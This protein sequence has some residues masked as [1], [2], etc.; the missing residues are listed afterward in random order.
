MTLLAFLV[1]RGTGLC[2]D[3]DRSLRFF[4]IPEVSRF[5]SF[6]GLPTG[7]AYDI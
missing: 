6:V 3:S 1:E 5:S 4:P 2:L 7:Q